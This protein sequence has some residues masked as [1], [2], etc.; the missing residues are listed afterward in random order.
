MVRE[1]I[2]SRLFQLPRFRSRVMQEEK[3]KATY[4][5]IPLAQI[6]MGTLVSEVDH[7]KT[8]EDLDRFASQLNDEPTDLSLPQWRCFVM[9]DMA[10]GRSL[11]CWVVDHCIADGTSLVAALLSILD[12]PEKPPE[13]KKPRPVQE[14]GWFSWLGIACRAIWNVFVKE[15][16]TVDAPNRLKE[17]NHRRPD[18]QKAMAQS[19]ALS[20]VRIKE[21]KDQFPNATVNDV[22]MTV[23]CLTLRKY[24]EKYEPEVIQ[25]RQLFRAVFP[26]NMRRN[27]EKVTD[28]EHF[29]N[30][31]TSGNLAFPLHIEDPRELLLTLKKEMDY[32]KVSPEP[33]IKM[34][35]Q[36]M[37]GRL[38][39]SQAKMMDIVLDIYGKVSFMLSN[40]PGPQTAAYL[41]GKMIS[42]MSFYSIS[43]LGLYVGIVSYNGKVSC[44]VVTSRS[45]E[46]R[47]DSIAS[48]WVESFEALYRATVPSGHSS[49]N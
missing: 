44:G 18:M 14:V 5:E 49:S 20:L 40:V 3:G 39:I 8:Q 28:E 11:L 45:C 42:D 4:V 25:N 13:V 48:L 1:L 47:P 41:G 33:I 31:F 46:P 36:S 27:N 43:P 26:I 16:I 6:D 2:Q 38:P 37:V 9:N 12:D 10:D 21:V 19:G 23:A 22:I 24:F 32:L 29:G 15:N 30:R 7:V 35:L 34:A 17:K